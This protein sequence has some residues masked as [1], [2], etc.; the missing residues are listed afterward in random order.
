MSSCMKYDN[1]RLILFAEQAYL[2]HNIQE[3]NWY[4]LRKVHIMKANILGSMPSIQSNMLTCPGRQRENL[5]Q[6][7][8]LNREYRNS[9]SML[10]LRGGPCVI[11]ECLPNSAANSP[12]FT[13]LARVSIL[14]HKFALLSNVEWKLGQLLVVSFSRHIDIVVRRRRRIFA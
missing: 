11:V 13:T 1:T 4:T 6:R 7:L 9:A 10:F 2:M 5:W 14:Y 12:L 3:G 8:F